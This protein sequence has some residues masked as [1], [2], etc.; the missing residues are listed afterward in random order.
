MGRNTGF[1]IHCFHLSLIRKF[2]SIWVKYS[3]SKTPP[4]I[5][6][7]KKEWDTHCKSYLSLG[8]TQ[9]QVKHFQNLVLW[10]I[11]SLTT[12]KAIHGTTIEQSSNQQGRKTISAFS[13]SIRS[14][15]IQYQLQNLDGKAWKHIFYEGVANCC[16]HIANH[17]SLWAFSLSLSLSHTQEVAGI[18][19]PKKF[20]KENIMQ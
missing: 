11:C 13:S 14:Q 7:F 1:K 8:T 17:L 9:A 16:S 12:K 2:I 5:P 20:G 4:Y 18:R 3:D 19:I 6:K 10:L 15:S